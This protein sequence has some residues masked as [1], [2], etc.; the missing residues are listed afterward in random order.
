MSLILPTTLDFS[1]LATQGVDPRITGMSQPLPLTATQTPS[2]IVVT[3]VVQT[4]QIVSATH[5][6]VTGESLQAVPST[7]A[8]MLPIAPPQT[9]TDDTLPSSVASSNLQQQVVLVS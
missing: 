3:T 5:S 2:V 7:L 4:S 9:V 8:P 6:Q 1:S